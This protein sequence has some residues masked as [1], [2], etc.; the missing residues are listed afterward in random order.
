M[1]AMPWTGYSYRTSA[2]YGSRVQVAVDRDMVAV[3]G[4]RVP[5]FLYRLWI[6][7]QIVLLALTLLSLVAAVALWDWRFLLAAL[8]LFVAH[9]VAGGVGAGCLWEMMNLIAFGQNT[10][11]ETN[12]FLKSKVKRVKIGRGWSRH[13]MGLLIFPY[14]LPING[15][16]AG[17][18]VSF[19]APD[20]ATGKDAVYA[21]HMR[22]PED[23]QALARA[24]GTK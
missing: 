9:G 24:L 21:L 1:P 3:T 18:C 7:V 14:V 6:G 23:A 11:G 10:P 16:A 22:T 2:R 4:P 20:G 5:L 8:L 15:I 13:G 17:L 19:E 12:S